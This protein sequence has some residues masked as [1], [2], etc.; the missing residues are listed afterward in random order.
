[1]MITL[2]VLVGSPRLAVDELKRSRCSVAGPV[3]DE[4]ADRVVGSGQASY[5]QRSVDLEIPSAG[6]LEVSEPVCA[7]E[8]QIEGII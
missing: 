8:L 4:Y 1:M 5:R 6:T 2:F 3:P 7:E